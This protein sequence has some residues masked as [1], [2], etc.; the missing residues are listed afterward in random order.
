MRRRVFSDADGGDAYG[1][2]RH[3]VRSA[4]PALIRGL[5]DVAVIT[6]QVAAAMDLEYVLAQGTRP[7]RP[8]AGT[9]HGAS[10]RGVERRDADGVGV[11]LAVENTIH[12]DAYFAAIF[13]GNLAQR[14]VA[15][16]TQRDK[17]IT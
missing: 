11:D 3:C 7:G 6:G 10:D 2:R 15:N 9:R 8:H 14:S 12:D 1:L 17:G 16:C 5:V 4:A 13:R